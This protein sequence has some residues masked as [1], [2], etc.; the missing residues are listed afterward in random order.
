MNTKQSLLRFASGIQH[1]KLASEQFLKNIEEQQDLASK[2]NR[3][4]QPYKQALAS[5][6]FA[7][8]AYQPALVSRQF[9]ENLLET[10]LRTI[11]MI[12]ELIE[13]VPEREKKGLQILGEEGWFFDPEMHSCLFLQR[14]ETLLNRDPKELLSQLNNYC[15]D[16]F[17]EQLDNIEKKLADSYPHRHPQLLQAFSAHRRGEYSL[18]IKAFLPEADGI[19][20]EIFPG[21][22]LFRQEQRK[23]AVSKYALNTQSSFLRKYFHIFSL[24]LPLW[25]SEF[26]RDES[27]SGFNRHTVVHGES[28]DDYNEENSL[29]TISLLCFLRYLSLHN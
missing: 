20:G 10:R 25:M 21:K 18:S 22:S 16:L 9:A 6:Q 24:S 27:F 17:R 26:E 4:I 23:S 2:I 5:V 8:E 11:E 15:V 13:V 29:K 12:W 7:K 19:F 28:L 14:I 3:Q 1:R